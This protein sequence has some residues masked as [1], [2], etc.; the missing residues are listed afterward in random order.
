M[1]LHPDFLDSQPATRIYVDT[2]LAVIE[3]VHGL[4]RSQAL[5]V[6]TDLFLDTEQ[7][8]FDRTSW[9]QIYVASSN[10]V[11]LVDVLTLG[12]TAFTTEAAIGET[13]QAI[14]ESSTIKK[15]FYD[16]RGDSYA[17]FREF[18]IRTN[19]LEDLALW[20]AAAYGGKKQDHAISLLSCIE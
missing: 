10:V 9:L 1:T 3:L 18:G 20:A 7:D 12:Q 11:Y 13:L 15:C 4:V 19:G 17:L 8:P 14:L 6:D 16:V 5:A 2:T